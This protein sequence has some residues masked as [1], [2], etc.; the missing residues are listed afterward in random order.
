M[1]RTTSPGEFVRLMERFRRLKVFRNI[2]DLK[3]GEFFT[4][5]Y[6]YRE[7]KANPQTRGVYSSTIAEE[8]DIAPSAVSRML[9][10]L[11]EKG[12]VERSVNREDRRNTF[13]HLTQKGE[14]T[15]AQTV[16]AM[17]MVIGRVQAR[18]GGEDIRQLTALCEKLLGIL[19][20]ESQNLCKG[21]P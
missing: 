11:E 16:A 8:L 3:K 4:L 1:E 19:E 2:T 12:Y 21:E 20:E 14:K 10:T 5:E 15:C 18:M 13:V 17:Q 7:K 9:R 6:L